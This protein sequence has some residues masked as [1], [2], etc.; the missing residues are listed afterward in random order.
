ML[1]GPESGLIFADS[2]HETDLGPSPPNT[3]DTAGPR[4]WHAARLV[5][6]V[7]N[8]IFVSFFFSGSAIKTKLCKSSA[9]LFPH[10]PHLLYSLFFSNLCGVLGLAVRRHEH[11]ISST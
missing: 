2:V 4:Q 9:K 10:F 8:V 5:N 6:N 11:P 3:K 7:E 1:S